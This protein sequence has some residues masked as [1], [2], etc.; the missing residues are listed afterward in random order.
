MPHIAL[1]SADP[2]IRG[3]LHSN[4]DSDRPFFVVTVTYQPTHKYTGAQRPLFGYVCEGSG[5][6]R[7]Q[8]ARSCSAARPWHRRLP[9][10]SAARAR[11]MTL[12]DL[13]ALDRAAAAGQRGLLP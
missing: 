12:P 11:L 3:C 1:N 4:G 2:G 10:R 6:S 9:R 13:G 7:V 8:V 5:A